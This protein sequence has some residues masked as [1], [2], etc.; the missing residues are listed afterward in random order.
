VFIGVRLWFSSAST[1]FGLAL[2]GFAHP[3]CN[4]QSAIYLRLG[5]ALVGFAPPFCFLFSTFCFA[6]GVASG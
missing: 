4:L 3:F 1:R 6:L 5:V 2:A